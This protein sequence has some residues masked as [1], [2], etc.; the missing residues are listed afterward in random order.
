MPLSNSSS[1]RNGLV[2]ALAV[3]AAHLAS[4][5]WWM[6][7][8][9]ISFNQALRTPIPYILMIVSWIVAAP[10]YIF[11]RRWVNRKLGRIL[12]LATAGAIPFAIVALASLNWPQNTFAAFLVMSCAGVAAVVFWAVLV[13]FSPG[14]QQ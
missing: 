3:T 12:L 13:A 2:V 11:L 10:A 14:A 8:D 9:Q 1:L 5:V 4:T 7:A 6:F